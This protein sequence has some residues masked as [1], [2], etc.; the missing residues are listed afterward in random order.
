MK[1]RVIKSTGSWYDVLMPSGQVYAARLR[2]KFKIKGIRAT[3]PIA[4][5]DW[6]E[7]QEEGTD[8][9]LITAIAPRENYMIRK[10]IKK[11]S[12][13]H[14]IAANLDQAVV[15]A[16]LVFPRTSLGFI[17]RFLVTAETFRI[18]AGIIFNKADLLDD[19]GIDYMNHLIGIYEKLGYRCAV[20]SA[21]EQQGLDGVKALLDQK[22]TLLSGHSGVG[23]STLVNQM[24]PGIAQKTSEVSTFANKGKHT[25]TFAEMFEVWASTF[26]IDTPGIKE[27]GLLDIEAE[28]LSHYF[29]EMRDLLGACKYHNC[30][31]THEP[32]CAVQ[33]AVDEGLIAP[34]RFTSY[35]SMLENDDSHR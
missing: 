32:G 26:I 30:T 35:L 17:D 34:E 7:V 28:E 13:G 11:S 3:N 4:V 15:V 21:T 33:Q 23:K 31:H 16:S 5:G 18:S 25:T 29:P 19:A 14:M 24:A 8:S 22:V 6:V 9:W 2:G 20:T 12:H 27:L 10:S 1:G